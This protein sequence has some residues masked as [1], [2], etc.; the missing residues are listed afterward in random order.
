M[1]KFAE[2]KTKVD[3]QQMTKQTVLD[4]CDRRKRGRWDT[5]LSFWTLFFLFGIPH[6]DLLHSVTIEQTWGFLATLLTVSFVV[7]GYRRKWVRVFGYCFLFLL[8]VGYFLTIMS[9]SVFHSSFTVDMALSVFETNP[10]EAWEMF[11]KL[12]M[13]LALFFVYY[14]VIV[15]LVDKLGKRY[16]GRPGSL[17]WWSLPIVAFSV[18]VALFFTRQSYADQLGA[19]KVVSN[20]L[21]VSSF[22]V[23]GAFAEAYNNK[24][25]VRL[26]SSYLCPL[27]AVS[28]D[29]EAPEVVV[30]MMGES[31][32]KK[33]MSIYGCPDKSTPVA[34][35]LKER[36]LLY[37]QA[38]A[39][40][41]R[42]ASAIPL[43]L[44][45]MSPATGFSPKGL[46]DNV[47]RIARH[48]GLWYT[49]WL[50]NQ[51]K[52]GRY[53]NTV[54]AIAN[55]ADEKRWA[56]EEISEPTSFDEDLLPLLDETLRKHSSGERL[57]IVM[58][59]RGSHVNVSERYPHNGRFDKF[60][61]GDSKRDEYLASLL[62]T[63]F[64]MGEVIRRLKDRSAVLIYTSDHAQSRDADGK[65][66]H[67]ESKEGVDVPLFV[68][69][70]EKVSPA[71]DKS[72]RVEES[73]VSTSELYNLCIDYLGI[74]GVERKAPNDSL[75]VLVRMKEAIPYADL[76][77]T[78]R[79]Q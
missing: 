25:D 56:A 13:A 44:C 8:S 64:L 32:W 62:Y 10:G 41:P 77:A 42:T 49:V 36:L 70:S 72:G 48:S 75:L 2:T 30:L 27:P 33:E 76:P 28:V 68:W 61:T 52:I 50:S 69:H 5:L 73:F 51:G 19:D 58:H 31:A 22:P 35:S 78:F 9:W 66:W 54:T 79:D 1:G 65:Y 17:L 7:A 11:G 46:S 23:F 3:F 45:R 38:V 71:F 67:S 43:E 55:C 57:F 20:T 60:D 74:S 53:D 21:D 37:R 15:L 39:A 18:H 29:P 16:G 6:Y 40:A 59:L 63:D 4:S 34:D 26:F 47:V 14:A 12:W 24:R